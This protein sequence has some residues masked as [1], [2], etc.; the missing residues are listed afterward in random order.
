MLFR[1]GDGR[2]DGDTAAK[3][4]ARGGSWA[5]R[6]KVTGSATRYGY[7]PWQKVYNVGI[8]VILEE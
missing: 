1:S 7:L 5:D 8:R 4:T 2:N 3:K 6:P